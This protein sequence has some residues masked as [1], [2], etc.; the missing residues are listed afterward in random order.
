[1]KIEQDIATFDNYFNN[2][3]CTNVIE[4]FKL[5]S[6]VAHHEKTSDRDDFTLSD[7]HVYFGSF[8]KELYGTLENKLIQAY[9]SYRKHYAIGN[10]HPAS[11]PYENIG[12][13]HF[14]IQKSVPNGGFYGWHCEFQQYKPQTRHR[15]LVWM[16]YLND[17]TKG[18]RTEFRNGLKLQPKK[19]TLV[20]WPAYFTHLHRAAPDLKET[21]YIM[22]GWYEYEP[23]E[24]KED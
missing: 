10:R 19:G 20:V 13:P 11:L 14:K 17:V 7:P 1:M 24:I 5:K 12:F 23:V 8:Q 21:K 16:L 9:S 4:W 18:G 3:Y 6:N 15:F 22:T 2:E